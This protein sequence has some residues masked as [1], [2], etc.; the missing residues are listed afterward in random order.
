[1]PW[2]PDDTNVSVLR[3]EKRHIRLI[4]HL[5]CPFEHATDNPYVA[6]VA[7]LRT[8]APLLKLP[9]TTLSHLEATIPDKRSFGKERPGAVRAAGKGSICDE[10]QLRWSRAFSIRSEAIVLMIQQ[11]RT[12]RVGR[13]LETLDV[14]FAGLRIVVHRP[15]GQ[16]SRITSIASALTR[17]PGNL[18]AT[19]SSRGEGSSIIL[20][21]H[22]LKRALENFGLPMPSLS[23]RAKI[24]GLR[25]LY[26]LKPEQE[27]RRV[28]QGRRA[29]RL[30]CIANAIR[31]VPGDP[32][33]KKL[34]GRG[35]HEKTKFSAFELVFREGSFRRLEAK[36]LGA[37][38][39]PSG[40]NAATAHVF[41]NDPISASGD[42][43]MR[44]GAASKVLDRNR[45]P[46]DLAHLEGPKGNGSWRLSGTNVRL[47]DGDDTI[48]EGWG[49]IRIPPPTAQKPH[50]DFHSRTNDFAAV[51]A[52][53]HLD[54]MFT[55]LETLEMPFSSFP[56][57]YTLPVPIIHRAAVHPGPCS[58][59][60][61]VNAQV[62][63]LP[64]N[65]DFESQT[66][67]FAFA[68]A[69]LSRNPGSPR[70]PIEPLGIACD[71]RVVWHEFC[72][73]LIAAATDFLE[74]PFAHSA[75]DALAAINGD[76][77]SRLASGD[78][79][80]E[81]RGVTFPWGETPSRRHDRSA[82][83]GWSWSSARGRREGY[84]DDA[85]DMFGYSREQILSSTLFRLYRA[86]GGDATKS[87]EEP[88][89]AERKAAAFYVTYLIVRAILSLGPQR[90]VPA[91]SAESFALALAEADI[92]TS[93]AKRPPGRIGGTV[94][95]VIRWAF[96][97]QGAFQ[98]DDAPPLEDG[99][100]QP[101]P[102]D[103][104]LQDGRDG[105]YQY[106]ADWQAS[107]EAIWNNV[108]GH[109]RDPDQAPVAGRDNF[110]FVR[111]KNRGCAPAQDV[112]ANVFSAL[113]D[114]DGIWPN[115]SKWTPLPPRDA[116]LKPQHQR[117]VQDD[118]VLGPFIW[119]PLA[120]KS[121]SILVHVEA[122]G[123]RSNINPATMLPCALHPTPLRHLVP[124]DNNIGL[125]TM[126][127]P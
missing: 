113:E 38:A 19:G 13:K 92:G 43:A 91:W 29:P 39:H 125:R 106:K 100:S 9:S 121:Y 1:M 47:Y 86:I 97:K 76:P 68:L 57:G 88:H 115:T 104:F 126:S 85:R 3:G 12:V 80:N 102:V 83:D 45:K 99:S 2:T 66:V 46:V 75:G 63:L 10:I 37:H 23:R 95:K 119:R 20:D 117:R 28:A 79:E 70:H 36:P 35:S 78:P 18:V 40:G 51:N 25:F 87:A 77:I 27:P 101:G 89:I 96:E 48:P 72:H 111:V 30:Y 33:H 93:A 82:R 61:C 120:G 116:A 44:P 21:H 7:Y 74:F 11:T 41:E 54:Q 55:L 49:W 110:I 31:V 5:L 26:R 62:R 124:N 69:D 32:P 118:L 109:P 17:V 65:G 114:D 4:T 58:D 107:A 64:R 81:Y 122:N 67:F 60:N 34:S 108:S 73:A 98:T 16:L 94:H 56:M 8:I 50:F 24:K 105:E 127:V 53:Y 103:V 71:V 52:Y 84:E 59:G 112:T 14:Q 123:D 90:I 6:A 15:A 42:F 22:D